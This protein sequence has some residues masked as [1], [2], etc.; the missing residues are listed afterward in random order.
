MNFTLFKLRHPFVVSARQA[1]RYVCSAVIRPA[2]LFRVSFDNVC[3]L[4]L[5]CFGINSAAVE[6]IVLFF[7][8]FLIPLK[9]NGKYMCHPFV[10]LSILNFS[11]RTCLF[12]VI[13]RINNAHYY[14]SKVL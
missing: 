10:T 5:F 4:S 7:L 14:I 6:K 8:E 3:D 13:P 1:G 11:H 9:H 2:K 12:Q